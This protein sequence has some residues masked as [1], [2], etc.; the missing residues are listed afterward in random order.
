MMTSRTAAISRHQLA[1]AAGF[2]VGLALW[3]GAALAASPMVAL[4]RALIQSL[5]ERAP[6]SPVAKAFKG[7]V[8]GAY[9][10]PRLL[11]AAAMDKL[12]SARADP[13]MMAVGQAQIL[14]ST[15][16]AIG[17]EMTVETGKAVDNALAPL[18][19]ALWTAYVT[20]LVGDAV[21]AELVPL[22]A[23][24]R[25][26]A[27]RW[28]DASPGKLSAFELVA[29]VPAQRLDWAITPFTHRS[30]AGDSVLAAYL[31][32][33]GKTASRKP[34][35]I[36]YV[37]LSGASAGDIAAVQAL[38]TFDPA[39]LRVDSQNVG[40][41]IE[42]CVDAAVEATRQRLETAHAATKAAGGDA[43][44]LPAAPADDLRGAM[45]KAS[46]AEPASRPAINRAAFKADC[47]KATPPLTGRTRVAVL[48]DP[49]R[50]VE[51]R[52]VAF[53]GSDDLAAFLRLV[54]GL[55]KDWP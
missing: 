44:T 34:A 9:L 8:D 21:A 37:E 41:D 45:D 11:V 16:D 49:K 2:A 38:A 1:V 7:Q 26:L 39:R 42:A 14:K 18:R 31:A 15:F 25:T 33:A 50:Q 12:A 52:S 6:A 32:G 53:D 10:G 22:A 29:D 17:A 47:A 20:P 28:Y 46:P 5:A 24:D 3:A 27:H 48:V 4:D 43:N 13:E 54:R 36:A 51:V 23:A 40:A 19:A 30:A 35:L 55:A